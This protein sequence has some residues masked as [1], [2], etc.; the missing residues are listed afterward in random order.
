MSPYHYVTI[1]LLRTKQYFCVTLWLMMMHH[2]TMSGYKGLNSSKDIVSTNVQWSFQPLL[3]PWT[4]W[5]NVFTKQPTL[6]RCTLKQFGSKRIRRSEDLTVIFWFYVPCDRDPI[7]LQ[8]TRANEDA[9]LYQDWWQKGW[10]VPKKSSGTSQDAQTSLR[11]YLRRR[12]RKATTQ[13][14]YMNR[15][16]SQTETTQDIC[17]TYN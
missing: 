10:V 14:Q 2:H 9:T 11:Y 4:Q 6:W 5:S 16:L 15:L 8:D 1:A 3:W 17:M 12:E 7:C 13:G